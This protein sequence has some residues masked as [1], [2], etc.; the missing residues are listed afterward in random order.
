MLLIQT[1]LKQ[2][3]TSSGCRLMR[4]MICCLLLF[5][6]C[7]VEHDTTD[8]VLEFKVSISG[9]DGANVFFVFYL[10]FI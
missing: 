2:V 8:M 7:D 3:L 9:V 4:Y 6:V 5:P 10:T 1:F